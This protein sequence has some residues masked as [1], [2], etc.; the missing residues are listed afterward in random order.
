MNEG[1]LY[2]EIFR[3]AY[4]IYERSGRMEGRDLDYWLE[5]ERIVKTLRKIG[6]EDGQRNVFVNVP[7]TRSDEEGEYSKWVINFLKR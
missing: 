6:E 7:I 4:D 3:V 5:A 1:N 2:Q